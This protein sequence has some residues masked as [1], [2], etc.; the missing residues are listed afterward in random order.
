MID[1][2]VKLACFVKKKIFLAFHKAAYLN[3][4]VQGGQLYLSFS[5]SKGSLGKYFYSVDP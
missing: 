3:W 5:F 1:L 2:L 4:L